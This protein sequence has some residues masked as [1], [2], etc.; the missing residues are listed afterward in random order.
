[1]GPVERFDEDGTVCVGQVLAKEPR[2]D[3]VV[4]SWL[5]HQRKKLMEIFLLLRQMLPEAG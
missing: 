2:G 5:R 4:S 3:S 1:M